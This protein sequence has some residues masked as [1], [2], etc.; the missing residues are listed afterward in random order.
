M[1][2]T[3]AVLVEGGRQAR[4]CEAFDRNAGA[5]GWKPLGRMTLG[6]PPGPSDLIFVSA[7]AGCKPRMERR[8][9]AFTLSGTSVCGPRGRAI[10]KKIIG[11]GMSASGERFS[12][13]SVLLPLLRAFPL[14]HQPAGQHSCG[15]LLHPKRANLL[16]E[17]G[18]M[19]ETREFIA[20]QRISR[21]GEEKFPRWLGLVIVHASLLMNGLGILIVS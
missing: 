20:L 21:S 14:L 2:V 13:G 6:T 8:K 4:L 11:H 16:A 15:I 19:A 3:A 18:G 10:R 12:R 5:R 17:V 1:D 9:M 7:G